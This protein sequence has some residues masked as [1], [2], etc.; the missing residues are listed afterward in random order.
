MA[1]RGCR[2][3]PRDWDD[4][5]ALPQFHLVQ[6]VERPF[7]IRPRKSYLLEWVK[8]CSHCKK[9]LNS[10]YDIFFQKMSPYNA[11]YRGG[12]KELHFSVISVNR[13]FFKKSRFS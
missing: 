5:S 12:Y 2:A 7:Q 4:P 8:Y 9:G 1:V 11:R 10:Q 13:P 6:M 3:L